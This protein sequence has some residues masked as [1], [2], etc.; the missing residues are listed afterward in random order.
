MLIYL[1]MLR[2]V[3][4]Q[5]SA[6]LSSQLRHYQLR[7]PW[8]VSPLTLPRPRQPLPEPHNMEHH[9]T[10]PAKP[11]PQHHASSHSG[12]HICAVRSAGG[13]GD[14]PPQASTASPGSKRGVATG[15]ALNSQL[16]CSLT[17]HIHPLY[18]SFVL[19]LSLA[20][21]QKLG[22]KC[23]AIMDPMKKTKRIGSVRIP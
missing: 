23:T 21:P 6:C 5:P 8:C 20:T 2:S 4:R 17:S 16:L 10:G 1:I 11:R 19:V 18:C 22:M 15:N 12:R 9:S 13:A 3:R 7:Q 14:G